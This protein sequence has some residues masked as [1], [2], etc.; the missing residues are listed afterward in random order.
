VAAF[1]EGNGGRAAAVVAGSGLGR[2]RRSWRGAE[3]GGGGE[4]ERVFDF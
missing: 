1:V 2:R 3:L 4:E